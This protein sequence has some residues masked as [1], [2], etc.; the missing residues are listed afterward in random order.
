M[1]RIVALSSFA[2]LSLVLGAN[3]ALAQNAVTHTP[4]TDRT[5]QSGL[6]DP[7][8]RNSQRG[9]ID[10][11]ERK[12]PSGVVDPNFHFNKAGSERMGVIMPDRK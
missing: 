7:N 10:P 6:V 12:N 11:N 9:I 4:P 2:A 3:A 5:S 1:S 8:D